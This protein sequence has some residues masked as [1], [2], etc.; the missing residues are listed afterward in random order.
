MLAVLGIVLAQHG[1]GPLPVHH[2]GKLATFALFYALP[3]LVLGQ[4]FPDAQPVSDP[5]G[6]AFILWGG[7]LYWWAGILYLRQTLT[8]VAETAASAPGASDTLGS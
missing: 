6:W 1:Y 5:L 7:F 4:A 8:L 2:L 3:L